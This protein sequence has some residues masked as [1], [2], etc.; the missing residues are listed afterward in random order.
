MLRTLFAGAVTG[1][2]LTAPLEAQTARLGS[3]GITPSHEAA[4][5]LGLAYEAFG[6]WI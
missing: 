1:L 2:L 5:R 6:D 4:G 3:F